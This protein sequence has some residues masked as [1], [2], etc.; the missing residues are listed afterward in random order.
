MFGPSVSCRLSCA[1]DPGVVL[2]RGLISL[3]VLV[4]A[5]TVAGCG[6]GGSSSK[7][8]ASNAAT[9]SSAQKLLVQTFDGHH[10]INSGVINL[11]VKIVP[12]DSSTITAPIELSFSGPFSA[13][14]SGKLPESDFTI[15]ISAQGQ[16]GSLQVISTGG[17]GY[18]SVS[19]QSY[20]LP[21]SSFKSVESG[22]GSLAGSGKSS[23]SGAG[24]GIFAKLGI[25]PLD[26]LSS[27]QIATA[28]ATVDGVSTT[29]IHANV[30]VNAMLRDVSKL[31]GK[32]GSLGVSGVGSLPKSIS[33][34]TQAR[35]AK[36]LG[37]PSFDVWTGNS[38][39]IVRKLTVGTTIPVT[40]QIR[41]LLGGMTSAK[42]TLDFGYSDINKPQTVT[43]PTSVKPYT[44]FQ[45]K[46]DSILQTIESGLVTGSL[47][48]GAGTN[49][50]GLGTGG[51]TTVKG[52][53]QNYTACIKKAAGDVKKMQKC[54]SLLGSG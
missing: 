39:K 40:G 27:A 46:V 50:G 8:T 31:L 2:R 16:H 24:S 20:V 49:T 19:G 7:T 47:T 33:P 42:F 44:V 17:K 5:G 11:D 23:G 25:Q 1:A 45:A 38:D 28:S 30:N 14:G 22:L 51:A 4:T 12:Q 18:V 54:S 35:I 15:A 48:S 52:V 6:S 21:A 36:I 29:Q 53:D 32:A 3:A 10:T 37:T 26:W 13:S 34:A 41:S 9:S 43:A